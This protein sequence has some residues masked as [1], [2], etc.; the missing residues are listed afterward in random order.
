MES[1]GRL[2]GGVAHDFN[3][4]LTVILAN[5]GDLARQ[6]PA[7][8]P[9]RE[10]ALDIEKAA[11]R[12]AELTRQLLAFSRRQVLQ[13]R[14][15]DVNRLV[16]ELR[17]MLRRLIGEDIELALVLAPD[18]GPCR[19]DPGQL[20][21]VIVNLAERLRE[22]ARGLRV[23]FMSGYAEDVIVHHG[24]LDPGIDFLPKPVTSD[25]LA[26]KLRQALDR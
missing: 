21:Q 23:V 19:L 2:A 6:L 13:P 18:L 25:A 15:V 24:M 22:R 4:L 3:N 1:V 17:S 10:A 11:R 16:S 5:S 12:A 8:D 26:A 9:H 20:E 7:G 14:I